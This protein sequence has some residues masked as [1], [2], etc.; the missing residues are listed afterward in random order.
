M[1][2]WQ[3]KIPSAYSVLPKKPYVSFALIANQA[4]NIFFGP[5]IQRSKLVLTKKIGRRK[6]EFQKIHIIDDLAGNI[7]ARIKRS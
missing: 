7:F 1:R 6:H 5:F 3:E 2:A 4:S